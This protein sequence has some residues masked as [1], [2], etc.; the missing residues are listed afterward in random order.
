M[1]KFI[2]L[3]SFLIITLIAS[4]QTGHFEKGAQYCSHRKSAAQNP[5]RELS[6]M[7]SPKHNFDVLNYALVFDFWDNFQSPYPQS[8]DAH[9]I[10]TIK[11]DT[12]LNL[13]KLNAVNNSLLIHSVNLDA[14]TF[15]HADDTLTIMLDRTFNPG[16]I[17]EIF[18]SYSHKNVEDGAFYVS[19][20]FVFTDNEPEGARKWF[21]CYDSPSDKAT[22]LIQAKVP[23]NVLMASNG[24]LSDSTTIA[25]TTWYTWSSRDPVATYLTVITAKANYN[26]DVIY[27]DRPSTPGEPMPIRF[28]YN[29]GENPNGMKQLVPLM[30]DYFSENYGEHPFEKD[31]FATL[32]EEFT[33]GGME[34]QTLTSLCAGC[35]YESLICHEF[36]HQWFGDMISPGTWA[37]IWLNEGFATWS[38][39]FWYENFGG[40]SAYKNDIN[41]NASY[42]LSANPGWA[43]YMPEWAVETPDNNTLFNYAVTYCKSACILHLLRY[44]LGDDLFFQAVYDYATDTAEFKY[45]NAITDDFQA[46]FEES[47][48]ADLDWFFE[49]WVKQPNHP[50]YANEYNIRNNGDGTWNLN[51]YANQVQ[52]NADFFP[53]PIELYIYFIGGT[54]STIRVM[55]DVNQ[56]I[57]TF[58]FD[59]Q[60]TNVFFDFHNEIVLKQASLVVGIDEGIAAAKTFGLEQNY[61]NPSQGQTTFTYSIPEDSEVSLALFDMAGK[62][63]LDIVNSKQGLGTHVVVSNLSELQS[64]IYLCRLQAAERNAVIKVAVR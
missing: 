7:N 61:P 28:Y 39:A 45:K 60:P 32:N 1:K 26:L 31:G 49:S 11:V 3:L 25:D 56:Q 64:G 24:S 30:A 12:A 21:P 48:G 54:D 8:F 42:Y 27:W 53:I 29:D 47:T 2:P 15:T 57:F 44:S 55:N 14:N 18:I 33:W 17:A 62:K 6:S 4:A 38:E 50:V 5:S 20:G 16:E 46:K 43:V 41:N 23:S 36:A 34:N 35:W 52:S 19:G 9:E 59:K 13:I 51:F 10:I 40:Y 63:V 58:T 37:D 22:T